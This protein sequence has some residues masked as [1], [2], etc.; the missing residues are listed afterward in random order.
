MRKKIWEYVIAVRESAPLVH[1]ITNYVVM[2]T[3]ANALLA[4]GASPIMAHAQEEIEDMVNICQ[5]VVINM[6]TLD[7]YW[8]Q[9]MLL[10]AECAHKHNKP[11][12]FD[13]VGTGASS[14]R[15]KIASAILALRPTVIRGNASEIMALASLNPGKTKG[16]DSTHQSN[17]A[18][19]AGQTLVRDYGA[20]VCISGATDIIL[21][22]NREVHLNNG[23]PLMTKVTGLGC[24][25]T[26]LLGAF[27][28]L[29]K[30]IFETSVAATALIS[31]A[32]EIAAEKSSGP[33]SLQ[34]NL[35]DTLYTL[36][37]QEFDKRL[38]LTNI[39]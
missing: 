7:P 39:K 5:S 37:E 18:I 20:V 16:V 17:E 11:F 8:S 23:H 12:I 21:S 15:N 26:A 34:L 2:N 13:P 25:A 30:D 9:S 38:K 32:G 31:I 19:I 35:L 6:G 36:T 27:S 22:G 1:N 14:Y 3:T 29:G 33:G 10:A 4:A 24:S 28:S